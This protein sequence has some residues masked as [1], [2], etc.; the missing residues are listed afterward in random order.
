MNTSLSESSIIKWSISN[1]MSYPVTLESH[2]KLLILKSVYR[3][4]FPMHE[5]PRLNK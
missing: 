2:F 4:K 3:G 1:K 5:Y